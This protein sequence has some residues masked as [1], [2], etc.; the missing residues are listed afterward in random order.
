[1]SLPFLSKSRHISS[2]PSSL[3]EEEYSFSNSRCHQFR[4]VTHMLCCKILFCLVSQMIIFLENTPLATVIGDPISHIMFDNNGCHGGFYRY[5]NGI[6]ICD[7]HG[8][9]SV[10]ISLTHCGR[11]KMATTLA[12]DIFKLI[13]LNENVRI[14]LKFSLKCVPKVGINNIAAFVKIMVWRLP[15]VKSSTE[16]MVFRLPTHICVACPQWVDTL[17]EKYC[18]NQTEELIIITS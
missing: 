14:S 10:S 2:Y 18:Y 15:G 8:C 6:K 5:D 13:F 17:L 1:M 4:Q 12:D 7:C 3:V 16:Q 9:P 11:D